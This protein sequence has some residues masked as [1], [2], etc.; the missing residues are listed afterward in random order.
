MTLQVVTAVKN[1]TLLIQPGFSLLRFGTQV[2]FFGQKG[3]PKR[4]CPTGLF[5]V[6]LKNNELKLR[7]IAFSNNSCY[8]PPLRHPAVCSIRPNSEGEDTQY[9]IHGGKTPN[10]ELSHK[11]YIMSAVS[12]VNKKTTLCC[13]EKDLEGDIPDARYGHSMSVIHSRG[14]SSVVIFG[15]RSYLP[16]NQRTT[17]TWNSVIDCQPLVYLIDLK[18]GCSRSYMLQELQDGISFH[19]ALARNDT[20]YILGGHSVE[21]NLRARNVYKITVDLPLGSPKVTCTVLQ[22]SISFSSAIATQTSPDEFLIVGGY[23]S[24]SHKR[25]AC[26][27]VSLANDTIDIQDMETPDWTGEITHSK[28]WFGGDMGHGV[29]LLGV[30][31]D[32]KH[33]SSEGN[34][35]FY[36]LNLGQDEDLKLQSC[37][38]GSN[39]EQEDSMPLE[40]SEEFTFIDDDDTYNEDD[41]E[42]ESQTGYWITCCTDCNMDKNTWVPFYS[43]ELNKPAMIYCSTDGGHWVHAQCMDLSESMLFH[44]SEN[45]VKYFCNDHIQL[46]RG[47]QTP[48]KSTPVIKPLMKPVGKKPSVMRMSEV[49]KSFLRRLF[50]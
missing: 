50:E 29:V 41:E 28:M 33:Q 9:L 19:A 3:W 2:F 22:G 21:N 24:D 46:A 25:L 32:N 20:V 40:D 49:K 45:N 30:P 13:L 11:L 38:Q 8:L 39:D 26:N 44:L 48:K 36:V 35:Y 31:S 37:S 5:L 12:Q 1:N 47:L 17:E 15:G 10:N 16:L 7:P 34:F 42:D 14:K 18:F 27:R 6:D 4:S 43:T 23:E